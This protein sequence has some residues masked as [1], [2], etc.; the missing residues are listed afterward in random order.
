MI[1][2][3]D[4]WSLVLVTLLLLKRPTSLMFT[5]ETMR[6]PYA[7]IVK[8]DIRGE[9]RGERRERRRDEGEERRRRWNMSER[10]EEKEERR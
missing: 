2:E 1:S 6:R 3:I 7:L 5:P 8:R 10:K 4:F 9:E